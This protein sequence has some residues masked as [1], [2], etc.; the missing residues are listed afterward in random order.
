MVRATLPGFRVQAPG[1]WARIPPWTTASGRSDARA[2]VFVA[3]AHAWVAC[4][5]QT[6]SDEWGE[7]TSVDAHSDVIVS[8]TEVAEFVAHSVSGERSYRIGRCVMETAT[9]RREPQRD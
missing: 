4:V 1:G 5:G 8:N 6:A 2:L 7:L 9:P 3:S